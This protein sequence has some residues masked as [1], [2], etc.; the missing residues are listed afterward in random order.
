MNLK[1]LLFA[2]VAIFLCSCES[3]IKSTDVQF[4]DNEI[5]YNNKAYSGQVWSKDGESVVVD[6]SDGRPVKITYLHKNGNPAAVGTLRVKDGRRSK[7]LYFTYYDVNGYEM[8]E[9]EWET[10]YE[11]I[12]KDINVE[13]EFPITVSD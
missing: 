5:I 10:K 8:T 9:H 4:V 7:R 3:K 2:V 13:E 6:V 12:F 1:K 11:D